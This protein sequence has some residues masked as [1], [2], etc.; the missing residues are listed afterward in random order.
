M[1]NGVDFLGPDVG[2]DEETQYDEKYVIDS[3]ILKDL[4][5]AIAYKNGEYTG[6]EDTGRWSSGNYRTRLYTPEQMIDKIYSISGVPIEDFITEN[7]SSNLTIKQNAQ[8]IIS[9]AFAYQTKI[10][11]IIFQGAPTLGSRTFYYCSNLEKVDLRKYKGSTNATGSC[12]LYG[13]FTA[14]SKLKYIAFQDFTNGFRQTATSYSIFGSTISAPSKV[15]LIF[16][17]T[18]PPTLASITGTFYNTTLADKMVIC[19][20]NSALNTWQ[21]ATNWSSLNIQSIESQEANIKG[22]F[23]W[24]DE[25]YWP[26]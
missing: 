4:A 5:N 18:T 9:Y 12:S 26:N 22:Q 11:S 17:M 20:P 24:L 1:A 16:D 6:A 23:D 21:S 14:C 2:A 10:K 7:I 15:Y 3:T 13:A 25:K 19:V 8:S